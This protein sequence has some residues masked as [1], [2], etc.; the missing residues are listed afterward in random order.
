VTVAADAAMK[1]M[2]M[3][4][5]YV[6]CRAVSAGHGLPAQILLD[7]TARFRCETLRIQNEKKRTGK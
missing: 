4:P 7:L 5:P 3:V 2:D 6:S 1:R